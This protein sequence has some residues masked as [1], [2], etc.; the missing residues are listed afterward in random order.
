M[1]TDFRLATATQGKLAG[2]TKVKKPTVGAFFCGMGGF[3]SGMLRA[4][5]DVRWANDNNKWACEVFRHRLPEIHLVEKDVWDIDVEADNLCDVDVVIGGFPCQPFSIAGHRR[6]FA[7]ERG[8]ALDGMFE[9]LDGLASKP[10]IVILENVPAICEW[11]EEVILNVEGYGYRMPQE[12]FWDMNVQRD[13]GIPQDRTRIFMIATSSEMHL[14][15]PESIT[16]EQYPLKNFIDKTQKASPELYLDKTSQYYSLLQDKI[17]RGSTK[18][19]YHLRRV[20]VREKQDELCPTLTANMGT[21]GHNVPFCKDRWGI[22]KLSPVE[23]A[24]LQGFDD[25]DVFPDEMSNAQKYRLVGN[26]VCVSLAQLV[27]ETILEHL[28]R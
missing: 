14:S 17:D 23:T 10:V 8:Q 4:G 19:L 9:V 16:V 7:D 25:K 12:N 22:R 11:A 26:A 24:R 2:E 21:G 20:Y 28:E 6:G 15:K 18:N 27:G 3:T 5:F 1:N 13:S